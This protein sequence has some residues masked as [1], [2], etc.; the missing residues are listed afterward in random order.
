MKKSIIPL[1]LFSVFFVL[2][3][4]ISLTSSEASFYQVYLTNTGKCFWDRLDT[5]EKERF[6]NLATIYFRDGS[7]FSGGISTH[8][9]SVLNPR[10]EKIAHRA[11]EAFL[12]LVDEKNDRL[13][14]PLSSVKEIDFDYQFTKIGD[15]P[16]WSTTVFARVCLRNEVVI[17]RRLPDRNGR[18]AYVETLS[19]MI[20]R[21]RKKSYLLVKDPL[22]AYGPAHQD[23]I[24][25]I[26]FH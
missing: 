18:D 13:E 17:S 11:S 2:F 21:N 3:F 24:M 1:S 23:D 9:S 26:V 15:Y 14:L 25:K 12:V 4:P 16:L 20:N 5:Y 19:L 22:R 8:L 10:R 6:K 7:N